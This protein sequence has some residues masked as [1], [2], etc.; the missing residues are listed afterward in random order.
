MLI[1]AVLTQS[2]KVAKKDRQ[3]LKAWLAGMVRIKSKSNRTLMNAD[4]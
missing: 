2:R 3:N 4:K 1:K